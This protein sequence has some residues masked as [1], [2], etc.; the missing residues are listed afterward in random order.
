MIVIERNLDYK[1]KKW[2]F[3][4]YA[5][6][7]KSMRN[8]G[9]I[10]NVDHT[11]ILYFLKKFNIKREIPNYKNKFW[12]NNEYTNLKKST[13][14]IG[15]ICNVS[16]QLIRYWLKKF[17]IETRSISET[18]KGRKISIEWRENI[19][20]SMIGKNGDKSRNWKGGISKYKTIHDNVRNRKIKTGIC[21]ICKKP[22]FYNGLGKL[23]LSNITG[24]LIDDVNNFQ[25]V[26][27]KCHV[28]WDIKNKII[29]KKI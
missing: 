6:L 2:L 28:N 20:K 26:H 19:S 21:N 13:I 3:H 27:H 23:E 16:K 10:C 17:D 12:L 15:K 7:E 14:E 25:W 18:N 11:S 24:K 9:K 1:N 4:Q 5:E 22:E 8:I 29:H